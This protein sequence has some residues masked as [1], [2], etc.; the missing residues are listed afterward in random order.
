MF[1]GGGPPSG[2]IRVEI[3]L[4][5]VS[6]S[7]YTARVTSGITHI[8]LEHEPRYQGP[9]IMTPEQ[10]TSLTT[11]I[12]KLIEKTLGN[13]AKVV[14]YNPI[15]ELVDQYRPRMS[16]F[17]VSGHIP[18][19]DGSGREFRAR[20]VADAIAQFITWTYEQNPELNREAVLEAFGKA[21][22][23]DSVVEKANDPVLH[24]SAR[25]E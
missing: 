24:I 17:Y 14:N 9:R 10:R 3:L 23:V 2:G 11:H 16:D 8:V 4:S 6:G 21:V 5:A 13:G 25:E 12:A 1:G 22:T 7:C 18:L 20:G 15:E 19:V